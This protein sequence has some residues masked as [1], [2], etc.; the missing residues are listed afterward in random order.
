MVTARFWIGVSVNP[1]AVVPVRF[2]L[3][4]IPAFAIPRTLDPRPL[5]GWSPDPDRKH[6][7]RTAVDADSRGSTI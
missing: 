2:F 7:N 6:G 1:F 3:K 4:D 5:R